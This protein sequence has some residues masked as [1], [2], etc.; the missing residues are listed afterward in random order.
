MYVK[1]QHFAML[2]AKWHHS[3]VSIYV[4]LGKK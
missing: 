2:M 4:I 1:H 3:D